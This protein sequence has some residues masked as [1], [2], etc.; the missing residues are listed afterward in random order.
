[1]RAPAAREVV[2]D[3]AHLWTQRAWST[4]TG[5]GP[6]P[7]TLWRAHAV[8]PSYDVA[9]RLRGAA[10]L[11]REL[12][13]A[14][15][16]ALGVMLHRLGLSQEDAV[17]YLRSVVAAGPGW[18]AHARWRQ[19]TGVSAEPLV[20][21]LTLRVALDV[22]VAGSR[23]T[24]P[25][26][27]ADATPSA[28]GTTGTAPPADDG[29]T[30]QLAY[31]LGYQH[32][33]LSDLAGPARRLAGGADLAG[34]AAGPASGPE[35]AAQLVTC[36]DV[37]SEPLRRA[38]ESVG[39][40][41][42]VGFAG[43]FGV[44]L[45]VTTSGGARFEQCPALLRP[46]HAVTSAVEPA[47]LRDTLREAVL[48]V[49]AAPLSPLLLAEAGGLLAGAATAGR[50]LAPGRWGAAAASWDAAPDPW[51]GDLDLDMDVTT[52]AAVAAAALRGMG[53][54]DRFAPLLV[55][56]GHAATMQNNAFA[57]AYDCGA[58]GGNGGQ[59]NARTLARIL[60]DPAVRELLAL[61]GISVPETTW[62]VAAVHGTTT[63]TVVIDP[64][65]DVPA[66]HEHL[67]RRVAVDLAAA[68]ARVRD[69]RLRRLP[70]SPRTADGDRARRHLDARAQDWSQAFPEWGLAGNAAVVIGPRELTRG[71]D[72][73]GRVFLHS[74]DP[75][76]DPDHT[77]LQ[78]LLSAP[79][80][81]TQWI[82]S[83]YYASTVDPHLLGAGDK[84]SHNVV[85]DVGVLT[86][87]HGDLRQGLPW[88]ALY[89]GAPHAAS[90]TARHEPMRLLAVVW[91]D[92]DV[93]LSLVCRNE[94]LR[95]LVA[96][97]WL[98]LV[99]LDPRDGGAHRLGRDLAWRDRPDADPLGRVASSGSTDASDATGSM[100]S[101]DVV[102]A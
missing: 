91:A 61:E 5:D 59:V 76:L 100:G 99:C 95:D 8:H 34:T 12:P 55:L 93:V 67:L 13:E 27:L 46:A 64:H 31:E 73:D 79:L 68:G 84:T 65:A 97:G 51:G 41:E 87:A 47:G 53:L 37:R 18:A 42:T 10:A 86:G 9:T 45:D 80:V 83:Q 48:A 72:L 56:C 32:D 22:L 33:L 20:E 35:P 70:G 1:M 43:F 26:A 78:T 17:A 74:Y 63:D 23:A 19:R 28:T 89:D 30:W 69:E 85:G 54:V 16:E 25:V 92:P 44:D 96:G 50:T 71:V 36:I 15:A 101:T 98:H 88:Q 62:V 11:V 40:Y 29:A 2:E 90:S 66:S 21:L 94:G 49:G 57:A 81:V 102:D 4:A 24:G 77:V 3:H 7:W 39:P 52:Q 60:D 14:P 82:S 75:A 58:C 6:G 38:L